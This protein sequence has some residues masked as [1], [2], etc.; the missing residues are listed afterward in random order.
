MKEIT[1]HPELGTIEYNEG[2]FASNCSIVINGEPLQR[3]NKKTFRDS[4]G[5]TFILRG[6]IFTQMKL[7]YCGQQIAITPKVPWYQTV[8]M[9]LPLIFDLIW[10]NVPALC[11]IFPVVGG[12]IGGAISGLCCALSALTMRQVK[13]AGLRILIGIGWLAVSVLV[14]FG[15]AMAMIAALT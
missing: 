3:V 9:L 7:D 10:G 6:S 8:L 1:Q 15:I 2:F 4:A 14:C 12:A 13:N 5:R 11:A